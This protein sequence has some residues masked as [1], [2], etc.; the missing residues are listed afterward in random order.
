M[1]VIGINVIETDGSAAPAI[2]AAPTSVTG[3]VL[4][5]RRGPTGQAVR[6]SSFRQ[7]AQRFGAHD[8]AYTGAY[9]VD[10]FFANG[11]REAWIVRVAGT[12]AQAARVTLLDR[13]GNG[14]LR[15]GAGYRGTEEGGTW[16]NDLYV[17]VRDNP[18][19]TTAL[20]VS[21]SGHQPARLQ[22]SAWAGSTVD[23]TPTN[24]GDPPRKLRLTIDGPQNFDV[25]FDSSA[26]PVLSAAT[27]ADVAAAINAVGGSKLVASP[28]AG[29]LLIVTRKKAAAASVQA[30][31]GFDDPTRTLLGLNVATASGAAGPAGPYD[32]VQVT[33]FSGFEVGDWVRL[34]DGISSDWVQ[35]T[36]LE[37]QATGGGGTNYVVHFTAPAASAQNEYRTQDGATL[38]TTEFDLVVRMHDP[39]DPAPVPVETWEKLSMSSA[40]SRYAPNLVNDQ[41][42]GSAY[43]VVAD[44]N[45]GSFAGSDAPALGTGFR[46]GLS[47]P[48]T[49]TL[50]RQAGANGGTPTTQDFTGALGAFDTVAV[51]LLIVPE[52]MQDAM[53]SAV[54][55]AALDYCAARG[56]CMFVGHTPPQR[57]E[58]GAKSFG[59]T[60]RS[61]KAYGALYWPWLTVT[62]P[63]GSGPNPTRS[64]PPSGSV[65]GIYART[66]VT[67]GIWKAPAGDQA[68]VR[69][70][71]DVETSITDEDH[72]DL[73][74]NGS[75][76]GIRPI[77][78]VGIVLDASRTLSTDT[79][80]L[81]VN[82]RLLFNF[83]KASMRDGLRWVKQEPNREALWGMIKYG[84]VTP[85]LLRLYQAGA[86]GPGTP[87]DVFTVVCGPE[88]N[89]PDQIDLGNLT[90]E[91]YFY[92]SRPAETILIVIGQQESGATASE[93]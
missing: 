68:L 79:R 17:D 22:G 3:V 93:G 12:G 8:T 89:P 51:Q 91:I 65:A 64:V 47:T 38:S 40:A 24:P 92:P 70:A 85:F 20:T 25:T 2:A 53:L 39:T 72:T 86:F 60:F 6:V 29:G 56:D 41:Y 80:W 43:V 50:T 44:Q 18:E 75:V 69:G 1:S 7:F 46:L 21:R 34:D 62:D 11:G 49:A 28:S 5:S 84:S 15:V 35:I 32:S 87:S 73:V 57:D 83:V 37:A 19:F 71:L 58:S 54:T 77:K 14:T 16:G 33:S 55:R 81:Y 42:S 9:G 74:K 27:P 23:L 67:R 88:N 10:G 82:V 48:S 63:V 45:A 76:N 52:A 4:R 90:V 59:Q 30:A 13:V 61:A 36:Q 66:D 31:T 78:G 26:V